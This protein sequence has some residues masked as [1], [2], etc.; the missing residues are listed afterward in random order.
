MDKTRTIVHG[1]ITLAVLFGAY[2][3]FHDYTFSFPTPAREAE[4]PTP[5]VPAIELVEITLG[6]TVVR[7][8]VADTPERKQAGLSGRQY[9]NDGE[10]MLFVFKRPDYYAFWMPDM[11]ISLDIIWFDSAFT[12]VSIT[13]DISPESYP[14]TFMPDAPAQYVLE[15]PAGFTRTH[16][17]TPGMS[18]NISGL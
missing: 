9:L 14:E 5:L 15:V 11:H 6:E 1:V 18:A 3:V 4:T 13:E 10:G 2:L 16:S 12:I 17:I 7:A 8:E